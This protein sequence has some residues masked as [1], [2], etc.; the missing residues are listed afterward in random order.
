MLDL[1]RKERLEE[2]LAKLSIGENV[3][4]YQI[5]LALT[6]PSYIYEGRAEH[7]AHNQRLEFLGDAVVG[8]IIGQYLF[9]QYPGK[10]EGELTKM[11]AAV[12]CESSLVYGA[13]KLG[14]GEYL[15]LGKGEEHMGGANRAS[16]LA[17]CFEAFMGAIYLSVGLE[18]I[19]GLVLSVLKDKIDH[20]VT[21][22]F[23]DYK[24]KLQ[25]Y[26]QKVPNG[27]LSYKI[28]KEEGPDHA[29]KFWAAVYLNEQE[30][31][32]G[33][34]NTKKEAEQ[35]AAKHALNKMGV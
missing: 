20:A 1:R 12:V 14:L 7:G 24:T 21:G 32:Q 13:K 9:E 19:R 17:D 31:A 34:G 10:S 35:M 16:N 29:K 6:H 2:L 22:D 11:R 18:K 4:I 33:N 8:L 3:D 30:L 25:E 26:I 15:L 27:V 23:G 28:I 5:H